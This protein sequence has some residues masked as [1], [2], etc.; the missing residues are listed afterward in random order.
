MRRSVVKVASL[1]NVPRIDQQF[2]TGNHGRCFT[3]SRTFGS[4]ESAGRG[5]DA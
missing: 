5:S 3:D 2:N 4:E 1:Q